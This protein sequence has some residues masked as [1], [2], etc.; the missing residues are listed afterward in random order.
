MQIV[1]STAWGVRTARI[2]L[3][4]PQSDKVTVLF[5]MLH[6]GESKFF[7]SVYDDAFSLDMVLVEGV[8][9]PIGRRIAQ[10][11][12]W[13]ERSRMGLAIQ[14]RYPSQNDSLAK[15]VH[16]DLSTEVFERLWRKIPFWQRALIFV[17]VPLIGL[18]RRWLGTREQLAK[19]ISLEDLP[20]REEYIEANEENGFLNYT[21]MQAR[22]ERLLEV[23]HQ[24]IR[25]LPDGPMS[26]GI[27]YGALHMRAVI[28]DLTNKHGYTC[29]DAEW[30]TVFSL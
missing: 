14:P 23:L 12:S 5:P 19:S 7:Q 18:Q 29:V 16:S 1:E 10:S 20:S 13:I 2:S 4:H 15:I 26:I 30:M 17:V 9:S 27:V 21:I 6:V 28:R 22:D 8:K 11:Y 3:R 24:E 25:N